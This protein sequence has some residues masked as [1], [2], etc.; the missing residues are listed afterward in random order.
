MV[1]CKESGGDQELTVA[2]KG[3]AGIRHLMLSLAPLE[4]VGRAL[5]AWCCRLG[6]SC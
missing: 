2:F 3:E 1:S 4:R 5:T 6:V